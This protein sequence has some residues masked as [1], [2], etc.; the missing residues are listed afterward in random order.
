[1]KSVALVA[2]LLFV[3]AS[4]MRPCELPNCYRPYRYHGPAHDEDSLEDARFGALPKRR[5]GKG[6]VFSACHS[7]CERTCTTRRECF[8]Q[9]CR[10]GCGCKYGYVRDEASGECIPEMLCGVVPMKSSKSRR[11]TDED[12]LGYARHNAPRPVYADEDD[13]LGMTV[14]RRHWRLTKMKTLELDEMEEVGGLKNW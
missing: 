13:S 4:A 11:L 6:E 1:M 14:P 10:L 12:S 7:Y 9:A 2:T 3:A 5:C 8:L